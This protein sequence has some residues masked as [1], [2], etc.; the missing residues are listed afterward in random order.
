[1][2]IARMVRVGLLLTIA[3]IT[4]TGCRGCMRE[5]LVYEHMFNRPDCGPIARP[6]PPL[7]PEFEAPPAGAYGAGAGGGRVVERSRIKGYAPGEE[8]R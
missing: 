3:A 4:S 1:M 8:R 6:C 2:P 5:N 7:I